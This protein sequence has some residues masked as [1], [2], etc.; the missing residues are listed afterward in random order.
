MVKRKLQS[1]DTV[2]KPV[3]SNKVS[4]NSK[5]VKASASASAVDV[6]T[7]GEEKEK[8]VVIPNKD[9]TAEIATDKVEKK[10]T[11]KQLQKIKTTQK[12]Q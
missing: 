11:E 4:K 12:N 5:E 9:Q 7:L 2:A 8:D 1:D 3:D 6:A 10:M